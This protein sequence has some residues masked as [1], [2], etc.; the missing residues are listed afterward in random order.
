[1]QKR[2]CPVCGEINA[3]DIMRFTPE[4]ICSNNN[5]YKADEFKRAIKGKEEFLTYS[6]CDKCDM[7]YC[8]NI[9]SNE[10]LKKIYIDTIDH[11][12]SRK[13]I[14]SLKKRI[15]LTQ[16]WM[17][18]LRIM[19]FSGK[20]TLENIKIIDYGCGWGDFID[21]VCGEGV[22]ILGYD[23]DIVKSQLPIRRGH[24]IAEKISDLEKFAPVD[25]FVMNSVLEHIQDVPNMMHIV[26]RV[27]KNGGILLLTVMD[28]RESFI[29][30]NINRIKKGM[31]ATT[32]NLNPVEHVNIY[33]Y[34]SVISTIKRYGFDFF[35]TDTV[36]SLTNTPIF[37][38]Q[39]GLIKILNIIERLL[40]SVVTGLDLG[41]S[42]YAINRN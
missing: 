24:K 4:M 42:V 39:I 5:T 3:Q 18:L 9:W 40:S 35:S 27:L 25:I 16:T 10:T 7:I 20:E 15:F 30:D 12:I 17:N 22:D 26:K 29:R 36:I 41:I 38:Y 11:V 28:Y 6:R 21:T 33:D 8:K 1:M 34:D 2:P 32:K 14:L 13:K 23:E 37:K 31:P 19:Y